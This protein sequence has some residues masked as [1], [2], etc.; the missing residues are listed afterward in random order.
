MA[1]LNLRRRNFLPSP[2]RVSD[3]GHYLFTEASDP[4][5][6]DVA[7]IIS[8]YIL[9]SLT[10]SCKVIFFHHMFGY[11]IGALRVL[12]QTIESGTPQL[13]WEQQ[14][15]VGDRWVEVEV[16]LTRYKET[17]FQVVIEGEIDS[18]QGDIA[19][20]DIS[21]SSGCERIEEGSVRLADGTTP[22]EGRVEIYHDGTWGSVCNNG[23]AGQ[24]SASAAC[25]QR[26]YKQAVSSGTRYPGPSATPIWL[27]NVVCAGEEDGLLGCRRSAWDRAGSCT[28][29]MDVSVE[30][31]GF[32]PSC[33]TVHMEC[34]NGQCVPMDQWCDFTDDC[35]DHTDEQQ[36]VSYPGR[37]DFQHSLCDWIQP[38]RDDVDWVRHSG[39][40]PTSNT[41]P[42]AD[43][44]GDTNSY[45]L[46]LEA[47]DSGHRDKA[48]LAYP[49]TFRPS[50]NCKFRF[51]YHMY[52]RDV[53]YLRVFLTTSQ[54]SQ[55]VW[56]LRGDQGNNWHRGVV[57]LTS[58]R[59]FQAR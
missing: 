20:D 50:S 48:I 59:N 45:Y 42:A 17:I 41:G 38:D 9:P 52:G 56:E 57:A 22:N 1:E 43:H 58:D 21:F 51:Y 46:Y 15:Q 40:T 53:G 44:L 49:H 10:D 26:G 33:P 6:G 14:S 28:H 31:A 7:R 55:N 2:E 24:P 18:Y 32:R 47:S 11:H 54:G 12:V 39:S 13:V 27:S 25:R 36:C 34:L 29:S 3:N 19:I 5:H 16:N 4:Q 35:G 8:P 37:C 30:C 23:W